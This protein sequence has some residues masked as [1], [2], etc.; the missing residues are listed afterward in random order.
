MN[1]LKSIYNSPFK[2]SHSQSFNTCFPVIVSN[3]SQETHRVTRRHGLVRRVRVSNDGR[4]L[5]RG[6]GT[7][8]YQ[9]G[10]LSELTNLIQV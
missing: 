8:A 9:H 10:R 4:D 7:M 5:W 3:E 2:D 1:H 6:A